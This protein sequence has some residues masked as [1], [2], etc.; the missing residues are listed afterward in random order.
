MGTSSSRPAPSG[1]R[2]AL[3]RER[4]RREI[5]DAAMRL[6]IAR[7]FDAVTIEEIA[8]AAAVAKR[9][10]FLHFPTKDALLSE[11]GRR[12]DAELAESEALSEAPPADAL[13]EILRFLV[14]RALEHPEVVRLLARQVFVNSTQLVDASVRGRTL[15]ERV[16]AVVA[17]GQA[18]G[19]FRADVDPLVVGLQWVG[20]FFTLSAEWAR[21]GSTL[22]LEKA[23]EQQLELGLRSLQ[24]L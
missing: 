18:S 13:S 14:R 6:F 11:Y 10:F 2:R 21:P 3:K 17:R 24:P 15:A 20:T 9:T 22:E 1:T 7:G 16:A 12:I 19:Q 23:V 5:Y 4:T 8:E